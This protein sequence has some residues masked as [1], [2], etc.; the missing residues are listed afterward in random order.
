MRTLDASVADLDKWRKLPQPH[1]LI[2]RLGQQFATLAR[3]ARAVAVGDQAFDDIH[4]RDPSRAISVFGCRNSAIVSNPIDLFDHLFD[5]PFKRGGL[6]R[7]Q[8]SQQW[9]RLAI[10]SKRVCPSHW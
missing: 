2:A 5:V 9:W 3:A 1:D 10:N 6:A 8:C 7:R 4:Y